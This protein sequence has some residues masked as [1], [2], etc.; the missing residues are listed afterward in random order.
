MNNSSFR[1]GKN[2]VAKIRKNPEKSIKSLCGRRTRG[3]D[4]GGPME[5][6]S[7]FREPRVKLLQFPL[8]I[9]K[10]QFSKWVRLVIFVFEMSSGTGT[11]PKLAGQDAC[12]TFNSVGRRLLARSLFSFFIDEDFIKKHLRRKTYGKFLV[13]SD[14][15]I[16]QSNPFSGG[17]WR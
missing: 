8:F 1:A 13:G 2:I 15:T 14:R 5:M 7:F 10:S 17:T 6:G 11:V 4:G 16:G 12:A 3:R 9:G